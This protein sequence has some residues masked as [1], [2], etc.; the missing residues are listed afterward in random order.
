MSD[1]VLILRDAALCGELI[2]LLE[3]DG[4]TCTCLPVTSTEFIQPQGLSLYKYSWIAFTSANGVRGLFR[5]LESSAH[6]LPLTVR[7]AAV[8]KATARLIH[9]LFSRTADIV[10]EV[11]DGAS[12]AQLLTKSLPAGTD[13]LYPCPGGHDS[14][15]ENICRTNGLN[16]HSLPVY[17]TIANSPETIR[18]SF[19]TLP[20]C[21]AAVFFAPSA[22]KA[23]NTA[24]P[25]PW[26]FNAVA[27]G[28]TT[29][30]AL[31]QIHQTIVTKAENTEPHAIAMAARGVHSMEW[32]SQ[33]A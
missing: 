16:I 20:P 26:N 3:A 13:L 10:S 12:L 22:V 27:I 1:H 8:G 19:D 18:S 30:R 2:S 25:A 11:A 21:D 33:H 32:E 17:Q 31:A 29:E 6:V 15:F 28:S 14:D 7:L 9:E 24:V 5:A 4:C 23:F